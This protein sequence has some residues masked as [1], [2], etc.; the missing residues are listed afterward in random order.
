MTVDLGSA[1]AILGLIVTVICAGCGAYYKLIVRM[2]VSD[3]KLADEVASDIANLALRFDSFQQTAVK[4]EEITR[5]ENYLLRTNEMMERE[6]D[7]NEK[8]HSEV[9][10]LLTNLIVAQNGNGRKSDN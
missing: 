10:T 8:R 5:L 4:R 2:D 6:R 9:M 3:Q 7:R 1:I